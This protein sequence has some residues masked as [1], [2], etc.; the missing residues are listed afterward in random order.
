MPTIAVK[1]Y[2]ITDC[3]LTFG[4][5]NY[6][7]HASKIEFV[8]TVTKAKFKGST[9]AAVFNFASAPDWVMNLTYAQDWATAAALSRYLH[10]HAGEVVEVTFEPVKGGAAVTA[11]IVIEPGSIGGDV[12]AVAASTVQLGV[13]G[14]VELE[15]L[16]P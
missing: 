12:D 14:Q 13:N 8:P 10:E 9:P 5:D 6:E 1:P 2:Q 4:A 7:A 3:L 16:T 11:S 15:P